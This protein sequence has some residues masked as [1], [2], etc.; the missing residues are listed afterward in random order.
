MTA[1]LMKTATQ[2]TA[3]LQVGDYY[4]TSTTATQ[5]YK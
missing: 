5:K 4:I 2:E 1:L 3:T